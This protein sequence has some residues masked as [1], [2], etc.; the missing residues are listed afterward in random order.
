MRPLAV[1][2]LAGDADVV[3]RRRVHAGEHVEGRRLPRAVGADEPLQVALV[4]RQSKLGQRL[5]AAEAG[6][7]RPLGLEQ[8]R[9]S[10]V[11]PL[12]LAARTACGKTSHSSRVPKMPCGPREHQ[13]D[14]QHAVDGHADLIHLLRQR[15]LSPP[16]IWMKSVR[17]ASGSSVSTTAAEDGAAGA[18]QAARDHH[19]HHLDRLHEGEASRG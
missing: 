15:A 2:A 18:A 19:H 3:P 13:D 4:D 10:R 11:M 7:V 6:C 8:R 1:T 16:P 5:Q 12:R 14:E 9:R 17:S